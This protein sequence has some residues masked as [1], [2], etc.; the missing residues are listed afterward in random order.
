MPPSLAARAT[1]VGAN[2][3]PWKVGKLARRCDGP[4]AG[5]MH[6]SGRIRERLEPEPPSSRPASCYHQGKESSCI[7]RLKRS[8]VLF[9]AAGAL[10]TSTASHADMTCAADGGCPH[11]FTCLMLCVGG[12]CPACPPGEAD[13]GCGPALP[14]RTPGEGVAARASAITAAPA[15]HGT[16]ARGGGGAISGGAGAHRWRAGIGD[17]TKIWPRGCP[18][19]ALNPPGASFADRS[20]VERRARLRLPSGSSRNPR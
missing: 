15:G 2:W 1:R 20:P 11:G 9:V 5:A 17:R 6:R 16:S 3:H 10:T 18:S 12:G 8:I 4:L 7:V 19:C 14:R 13:G